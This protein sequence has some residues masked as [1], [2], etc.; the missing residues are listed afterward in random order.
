M[1]LLLCCMAHHSRAVSRKPP[2]DCDVDPET[3]TL[4]PRAVRDSISSRT[5]AVLAVDLFGVPCD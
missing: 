3:L 4:D 1:L 5:R 2:A